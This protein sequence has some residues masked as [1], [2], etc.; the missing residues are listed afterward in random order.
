MYRVNPFEVKIHLSCHLTDSSP[1]INYNNKEVNG[2]KNSLFAL[3]FARKVII[4]S[5]DK[6]LNTGKAKSLL[7]VETALHRVNNVTYI[8]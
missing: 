5:S 4:I 2:I 8:K 1:Y 3:T 6:R 7:T